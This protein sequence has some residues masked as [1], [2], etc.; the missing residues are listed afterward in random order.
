MNVINNKNEDEKLRS[1]YVILF[2]SVLILSIVS[3]LLIYYFIRYKKKPFFD[4][5]GRKEIEMTGDYQNFVSKLQN[6]IEEDDIFRLEQ[7]VVSNKLLDK[8]LFF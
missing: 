4:A 8:S 3:T 5:A 7:E 6:I 1:F 2:I